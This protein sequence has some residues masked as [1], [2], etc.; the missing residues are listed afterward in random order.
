M[1]H[2]CCCVSNSSSK[3]DVRQ[4]KERNGEPTCKKNVI[5]NQKI[6]NLAEDIKHLAHMGAANKE[7]CCVLP[8]AMGNM[9]TVIL[10]PLTN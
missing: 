10:A 3:R 7:G 8:L 5:Q 9:A 6:M 2:C 4:D 1:S